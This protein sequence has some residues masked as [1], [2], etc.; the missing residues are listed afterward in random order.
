M[1]TM[2]Y[3]EGGCC[4]QKEKVACD[5]EVPSLH[6]QEGVGIPS[7]DVMDDEEGALDIEALPMWRHSHSR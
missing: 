1:C 3:L 6:I 5:E 7:C 4:V 2:S